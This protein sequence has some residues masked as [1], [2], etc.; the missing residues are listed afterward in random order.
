MEKVITC[1]NCP[2][3]C[4]LTVTLENDQVTKVTGNTCIR[5]DKYARQE[6]IAPE[7]MITAVVP[8]ADRSM[9]LSVKTARPVPKKLI[10][11]CMQALA[12][13]TVTAPVRIGDVILPNVCGT[14]VDVIATRGIE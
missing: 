3:G 7:R 11:A 1:I 14:G 9:P 8:V 12:D 10:S 2:V 5:G 4:R 13:V 6:C